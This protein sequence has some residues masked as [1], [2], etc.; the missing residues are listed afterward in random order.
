MK[1]FARKAPPAALAREVVPET[2]SRRVEITVEREVRW[3]VQRENCAHQ[4]PGAPPETLPACPVCGQALPAPAST[5]ISS[6]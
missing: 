5:E 2:V 6:R 4:D 1:W 3:T